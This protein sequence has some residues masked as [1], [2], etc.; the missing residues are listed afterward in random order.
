MLEIHSAGYSAGGF[1]GSKLRVREH[2]Q[3]FWNDSTPILLVVI[4]SA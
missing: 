4:N 2:E 3:K 1:R